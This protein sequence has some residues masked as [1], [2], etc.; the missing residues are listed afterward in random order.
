MFPGLDRDLLEAL[1]WQWVAAKASF[2][3]RSK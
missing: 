2:L 1:A 3:L